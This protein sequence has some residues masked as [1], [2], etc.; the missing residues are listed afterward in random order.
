VA[1]I[2]IAG[3]ISALGSVVSGVGTFM[4]AQAQ[5]NINE[6]NAEIADD[7]AKRAIERSQLEQQDMDLQTRAMVGE[8]LA[9]QSASGVDVGSGSTKY[10]RMAARELG[11]RDALN[12]R[13]AGE[14][15]AYDY[16][17]QA[18]S[19]RA[20]ASATRSGGAFG[21]LSGFLGAGSAITGAQKVAKRNYAPTPSPRP[22]VLV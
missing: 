9:Q 7:N 3:V 12:V 13:Q 8:Q 14:L 1:Q 15:E 4:A 6:M 11:R 17:T 5:A 16:K 22:Q 20:Q 21:L 18:V 10:T 2:G 19:Q